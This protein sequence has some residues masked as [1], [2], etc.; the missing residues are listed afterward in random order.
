M[1]G[2]FTL[3]VKNPKVQFFIFITINFI[4]ICDKYKCDKFGQ[5]Q[6]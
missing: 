2:Q 6:N 5:S 1:M 3:F 4:I